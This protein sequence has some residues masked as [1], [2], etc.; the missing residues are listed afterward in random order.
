MCVCVY[1][2]VCM[3]VYMKHS[4]LTHSRLI[5]DIYL[6]DNPVMLSRR[7][8]M[9]GL[10]LHAL[11][12]LSMWCS[13]STYFNKYLHRLRYW[14]LCLP[15]S[16]PQNET[17]ELMCT[18]PVDPDIAYSGW[19]HRRHDIKYLYLD[20]IPFIGCYCINLT[21]N[22]STTTPHLSSPFVDMGDSGQLVAL[23][24]KYRWRYM[25]RLCNLENIT[26]DLFQ[27]MRSLR[28]LTL[29]SRTLKSVSDNAF[30]DTPCMSVLD[31]GN[32][33]LSS[34]LQMHNLMH[35]RGLSVSICTFKFD[36]S[37][38]CSLNTTLQLRVLY[39]QDGAITNLS[40]SSFICMPFLW[41]LMLTNNSII[42]LHPRV[43]ENLL[44]LEI[45]DLSKNSIEKIEFSLF[46]SLVSMKILDLSDNNLYYFNASWL[47]NMKNLSDI[48]LQRNALFQIDGSFDNNKALWIVDLSDNLIEEI[49][50]NIFRDVNINTVSIDNNHLT[51]IQT[52]AF[53]GSNITALYMTSNHLTNNGLPRNLFN[54]L[55]NLWI[56]Q[57]SNNRIEYLSRENLPNKTSSN[58]FYLDLSRNKISYIEPN[59]FANISF[60]RLSIDYNDLRSLPKLSSKIEILG[61]EMNHIRNICHSLAGLHLLKRLFI[62]HNPI[63]SLTADCFKTNKDLRELRIINAFLNDLPDFIFQSNRR[64]Q[65]LSLMK[66]ML[67]LSFKFRPQVLENLVMLEEL[68]LSN[69]HLSNA[70]GI[71]QHRSKGGIFT[72]K[73]LL[74]LGLARNKIKTLTE[75][76]MP[77]AGRDRMEYALRSVYL[78][79]N[80]ISYISKNAFVNLPNLRMVNLTGN[81]I[82]VFEPIC[83]STISTHFI[84]WQNP[85]RCDCHM[86]WIKQKELITKIYTTGGI[87]DRYV[88]YHTCKVLTNMFDIKLC[89]NVINN[90]MMPPDMIDSSQFLCTGGVCHANCSCYHKDAHQSVS[91]ANCNDRNLTGLPNLP[92]TI[93]T[94]YLDGNY[95]PL[96]EQLKYGKAA[97]ISLQHNQIEVIGKDAFK[98]CLR[99]Q[100]LYLS[101]NR[102]TVLPDHVFSHNLLL[103]TLFL[104]GNNLHTL[105]ALTFNHLELMTVLHIDS[106]NI[107]KLETPLL[108]YIAGLS[109]ITLSNNPWQCECD[110][111]TFRLV[112]VSK[113]HAIKDFNNIT[114]SNQTTPISS[115]TDGDFICPNVEDFISTT[116]YS[117]AT[118]KITIVVAVIIVFV[119]IIMTVLVYRFRYEIRVLVYNA[120]LIKQ[121][122]NLEEQDGKA[123]DLFFYF[124]DSDIDFVVGQF[125]PELRTHMLNERSI[126]PHRDFAAGYPVGEAILESIKKS[127]R[128]V[129]FLSRDFLLD[130][131]YMFAFDLAHDFCLHHLNTRIIIILLDDNAREEAHNKHLKA[132]LRTKHFIKRGE[133]LFWRKFVYEAFAERELRIEVEEAENEEPMEQ[134]DLLLPDLE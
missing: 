125:Y 94:L 72:F 99:L 57:L 6:T 7:T 66:N 22:I 81:Q 80:Q 100:Y 95:Y 84:L 55:V 39:M 28:N 44:L 30:R 75:L 120:R 74:V 102:L 126:I 124:S 93:K 9:F 29:Q 52:N 73:R 113:A 49:G 89:E 54:P 63:Y 134:D 12:L 41:K 116:Q 108:N 90:R 18:I 65:K 2:Y 69:N 128:V 112:L 13:V 67:S 60:S 98:K 62:S 25:D 20:C 48:Y 34:M 104:N 23:F 92:N 43:F 4:F 70:E 85:L 78:E 109:E 123:Y 122:R 35:L 68:D 91:L 105:H 87:V 38:R 26:D 3:Y 86:Q 83:T 40:E 59:T 118:V 15:I 33:S 14:N 46:S 24:N 36:P 32:S 61:A 51:T 121:G 79:N 119:M 17:I 71:I 133:R 96:L 10:I 53:S 127:R 110:N 97:Y 5:Y 82:H 111:A 27:G 64:L 42:H 45:L 114:C 37:S 129:L 16:S 115:M 117:S 8:S 101:F 47:L 50:G 11:L 103:E 131:W 77:K 106:N 1:M 19:Y 88:M 31:L 21:T 132:Y 58:R 56:L 107:R 130:D 76:S